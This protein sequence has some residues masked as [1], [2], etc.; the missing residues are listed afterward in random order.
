MVCVVKILLNKIKGLIYY[1]LLQATGSRLATFCQS[2]SS[3][4]AGIIIGFIYSWELTLLILGFAPFML[5]SG[6]IQMK[7]LSGNAGD[8]KTALENAGKVS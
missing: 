4:G 3:I 1:F 5:A 6:F 8:K 7:V 2:M